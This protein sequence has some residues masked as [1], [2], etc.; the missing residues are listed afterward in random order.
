[1]VIQQQTLTFTGTATNHAD[2]DDVA[3]LTFTFTDDAFASSDA[4]DV[5]LAVGHTNVLGIDFNFCI[6]EIVYESGAWTGGNNAGV[7]DDSPT[8]L[9]K[10]VNVRENVTITADVNCDCLRI[11][12]GITLTVA[13]G[14]KLEVTNLLQMEGDLRLN[15]D[16]Q[17][18]QTFSGAKN[19][20]GTGNLT[21]DQTSATNNVYQSGYW[22]APATTN[23]STFTIGGVM[24]DGTTSTP[25]DITFTDIHTLDGDGTTSPITVSGRWLARISNALT[26]TSFLDPAT[27]IFNPGEA[28]NMKG[29]G[30]SDGSSTQNYSFVGYPNAGD[31]SLTIDDVRLYLIGNPYPS[32]FRCQSIYH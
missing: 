26:W 8:D 30:G 25:Q 21:V 15:G 2:S 19:D 24:K 20:S 17:L 10:G 1:M 32:A 22:T 11:D 12:S 13:D 5:A 16:A 23:G 27:E 9:V 6:D 28:Y 31:Y 18:L 29:T 3:N 7:P 4:T 14:I